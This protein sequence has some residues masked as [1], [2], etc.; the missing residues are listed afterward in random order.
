M[1]KQ[2]V[3]TAAETLMRQNGQTTTLEVKNALRNQGY[4]ATQAAVS[5]SMDELSTELPWEYDPTGP[6][7]IYRLKDDLDKQILNLLFSA[8]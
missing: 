8:N 5:E 4:F 2:A 6:F 1:T 7:R 3:Q